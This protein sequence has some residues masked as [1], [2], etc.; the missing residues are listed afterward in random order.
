MTQRCLTP[1][2]LE[3]VNGDQHPGAGRLFFSDASV[4]LLLVNDG[5][6]RILTRLTGLSGLSS[7]ESLVVT[8]LAAGAVAKAIADAV[9]PMS[10]PAAPSTMDLILGGSALNEIA[11]SIGGRASRSVP[12]FGA[13]VAFALIWR[14]H[15]LARGSFSVAR[16]STHAIEATERRL[17]AFYRARSER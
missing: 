12:G 16:G 4:V 7:G 13:L 14:Y 9:P 5:R 3:H 2:M 10:R 1:E 11:H 8:L 6:R 15:P 17:R